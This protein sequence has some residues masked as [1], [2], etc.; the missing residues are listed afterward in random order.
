MDRAARG[1]EKVVSKTEEMS[2]GAALKSLSEQ[3]SG[4]FEEFRSTYNVFTKEMAD[5]IVQSKY[6]LRRRPSRWAKFVEIVKGERGWR[7][8][9]GE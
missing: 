6:P 2:A 3:D 5:A 8:W 7:D 1:V 4:R 9:G